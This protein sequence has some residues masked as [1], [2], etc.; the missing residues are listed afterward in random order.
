MNSFKH[1]WLAIE[2]S[3]PVNRNFQR[4][5]KICDDIIII[6]FKIILQHKALHGICYSYVEPGYFTQAYSA[7][8]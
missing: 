1:L 6:P 3:Y 7:Y 2:K 5:L 4:S 8:I